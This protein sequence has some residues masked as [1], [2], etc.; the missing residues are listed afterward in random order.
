[1]SLS[2]LGF[3][4]LLVTLGGALI[5]WVVVS[6]P[7]YLAGRIVAKRRAGIG[8]AMGATLLGPI[9]YFIV[10]LGSGAFLSAF[11]GGL[12]SVAALL[13]AF[14]A[15]LGVYKSIFRTG[16]LGALGIAIIA[17]IVFIVLALLLGLVLGMV[18]PGTVFPSPLLPS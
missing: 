3:I 10:L 4:D 13:L 9:V 2:G 1:M 16:W 5:L 6:I 15:W 7:V 11:L 17:I 12:A 14:L 18:L 8:R